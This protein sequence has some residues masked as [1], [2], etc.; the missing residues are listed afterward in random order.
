MLEIHQNLSFSMRSGVAVSFLSY[1]FGLNYLNLGMCITIC[2]IVIWIWF[3][4]CI[5]LQCLKWWAQFFISVS[6][7]LEIQALV[8]RNFMDNFLLMLR[9]YMIIYYMLFYINLIIICINN[10]LLI[11][12]GVDFTRKKPLHCLMVQKNRFLKS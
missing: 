3:S 9:L 7:S 2:E 5:I 1:L 6:C 8:E 12:F 11:T 10:I 4:T